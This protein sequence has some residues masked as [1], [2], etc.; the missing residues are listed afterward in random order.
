MRFIRRALGIG[1]LVLA[2]GGCDN[3]PRNYNFYVDLNNDK[4]QEIVAGNYEK[5]HWT[6]REY[7]TSVAKNDGEGNFGEPKL[8][9]RQK[10]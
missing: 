3:Q 8:I 4:R 9:N 5:E 7:D 6:Y 10:K 1:A 2:L